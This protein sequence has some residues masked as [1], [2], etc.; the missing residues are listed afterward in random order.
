MNPGILNTGS[1]VYETRSQKMEE[2][3]DFKKSAMASQKL[4]D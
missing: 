2:E 3:I 1:F 4:M